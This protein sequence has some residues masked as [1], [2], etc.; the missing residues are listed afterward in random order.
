MVTAQKSTR[1]V[2]N[3]LKAEKHCPLVKADGKAWDSRQ[4]HTR[5]DPGIVQLMML[6]SFSLL[7]WM[8]PLQG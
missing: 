4:L 8:S 5:G 3:L 1:S 6:N 7:E 2:F